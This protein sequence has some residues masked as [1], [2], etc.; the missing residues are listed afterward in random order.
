MAAPP[1][2]PTRTSAARTYRLRKAAAARS[3]ALLYA[4]H[5]GH[6]MNQTKAA[7]ANVPQV[8]A[9]RSVIPALVITPDCDVVSGRVGAARGADRVNPPGT[10]P[11]GGP[12][13]AP[14]RGP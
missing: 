5:A 11:P 3:H 8:P 2:A 10:D 13:R 6:A 1:A 9:M 4:F 7:S 14:G 12:A